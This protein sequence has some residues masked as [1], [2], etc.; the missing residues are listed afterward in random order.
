MDPKQFRQII[1]EEVT[2][3]VKTELKPIDK[4]LGNLEDKVDA[5]SGDVEQLHMDVKGIR[6][7]IGLWHQIVSFPLNQTYR[8]RG[9][10]ETSLIH[11]HNCNLKGQNSHLRSV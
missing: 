6:D 5:L 2:T 10:F 9:I 7:E 4:L 3:V 8:G 1:R 11:Y